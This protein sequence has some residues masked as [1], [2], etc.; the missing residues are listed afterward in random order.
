MLGHDL[1]RHVGLD[2]QCLLMEVRIDV[3]LGSSLSS[4]A[5]RGCLL[6]RQEAP[7]DGV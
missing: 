6:I 4:S 5:A 2:K 3:V 7:E 1:G